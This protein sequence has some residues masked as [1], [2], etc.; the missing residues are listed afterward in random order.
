MTNNKNKNVELIVE[1]YCVI[2]EEDYEYT[3]EEYKKIEDLRKTFE[4]EYTI[5]EICLKCAKR[6]RRN[7]TG[8]YTEEDCEE[9]E[10]DLL[11][12]GFYLCSGKWVCPYGGIV[13]SYRMFNAIELNKKKKESILKQEEEVVEK[14]CDKCYCFINNCCCEL[15][16][17]QVIKDEEE[18]YKKGFTPVD[19]NGDIRW[20]KLKK[21]SK[22]KKV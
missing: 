4:E 8:L 19:N 10:K 6:H 2:C 12:R 3:F 21:S 15:D 5:E 1:F 20:I 14:V 13:F 17:L 16:R 11:K 9:Q 18:A 7:M 22:K